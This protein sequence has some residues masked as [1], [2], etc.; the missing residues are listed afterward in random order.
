VP[1]CSDMIRSSWTGWP[2]G[3]M[4]SDSKLISYR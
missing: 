2:P 3:Q 4:L 1:R